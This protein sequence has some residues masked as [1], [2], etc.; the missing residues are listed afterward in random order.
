M[1]ACNPLAVS[2]KFKNM[3]PI[4]YPNNQPG[5]P[6]EI[7][8]YILNVCKQ[9]KEEGRALAFAFII[10]DLTD[11]HVNKILRDND[12]LNALHNISG[13]FLTVFFLNDSYVD[14]TLNQ[15]KESNVIRLELGIEKID[16]PPYIMPKQLAQVLLNQEIL[17]SPSILF[18]QVENDVVTDYFITN[19]R[20]NK[21][22]NGFNEIKNII[23]TAVDSF[24]QVTP[25]NESNSKELFTLLR[26]SIDAS[27]FWKNAK[28]TYEKVIKFKDF[29][30]FWR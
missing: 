24:K 22:E 17:S 3:H 13:K 5:G 15:A 20:E 29:I 1:P 9:H 16:A 19:L 6:R 30:F 10:T 26:Q 4:I 18:F 14:Q 23:K 2:F 21:I 11:P 28:R 27:E 25:E 7:S 8:A 12:Y